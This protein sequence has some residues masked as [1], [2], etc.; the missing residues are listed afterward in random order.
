MCER[1]KLNPMENQKRV[2]DDGAMNVYEL[3]LWEEKRSFIKIS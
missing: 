3:V 1:K 2:S